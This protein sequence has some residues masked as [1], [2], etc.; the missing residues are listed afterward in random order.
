[1]TPRKS[2]REKF[3]F[4]LVDLNR[5]ENGAEDGKN[6]TRETENRSGEMEEKISFLF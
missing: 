5:R 4:H 2:R 6:K 1:M 3:V